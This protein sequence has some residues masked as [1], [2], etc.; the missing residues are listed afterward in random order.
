MPWFHN[1]CS[2]AFVKLPCFSLLHVHASQV[3]LFNPAESASAVVFKYAILLKKTTTPNNKNGWEKLPHT[4]NVLSRS[5][6]VCINPPFTFS[7]CI[8]FWHLF[9]SYVFCS[10]PLE[11]PHHREAAEA[12]RLSAAENKK[13]FGGNSKSSEP[14]PL[15]PSPCLPH[16]SFKLYQFH[17]TLTWHVQLC[18]N[19]IIA[20]VN[21]IFAASQRC[22]DAAWKS[23]A[24]RE[25]QRVR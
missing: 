21:V 14:R 7:S 17:F 23:A 10:L 13:S 4:S 19:G 2:R 11:G 18:G 6:T 9:S 20:E 1:V 15:K 25:E 3:M 16:D 22:C 12:T 8:L 24:G 5:Y